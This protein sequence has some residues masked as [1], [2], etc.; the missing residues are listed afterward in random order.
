MGVDGA[1]SC[2]GEL[3]RRRSRSGE[4][5]NLGNRH[6][7][8]RD[9]VV[10]RVGRER[11]FETVLAGHEDEEAVAWIHGRGDRVT[12][13]RGER[14]QLE[15]ESNFHW[16]TERM[17]RG[18]VTSH[19]DIVNQFSPAERPYSRRAYTDGEQQRVALGRALIADRRFCSSQRSRRCN[20][21]PLA[22][23]GMEY[24]WRLV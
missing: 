18:W 17:T 22:R 6:R 2:H 15:F 11:V 9:G 5:E 7:I 8:V 1:V 3:F 16:L 14:R 23:P 10:E 13:F 24:C 19:A 21:P 20:E 4:F 12:V